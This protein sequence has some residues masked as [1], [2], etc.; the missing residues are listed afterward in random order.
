MHSCEFACFC[1]LDVLHANKIELDVADSSTASDGRAS[2]TSMP[3][4]SGLPV[5]LQDAGSWWCWLPRRPVCLSFPAVMC[6]YRTY[7]IARLH[8]I[9]S[10]RSI[11]IQAMQASAASLFSMAGWQRW[12]PEEGARQLDGHQE[13]AP[14]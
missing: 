8:K 7:A 11:I 9:K 4:A 5:G 10:D 6:S 14:L 3:A 13:G 12:W 1:S 2:A